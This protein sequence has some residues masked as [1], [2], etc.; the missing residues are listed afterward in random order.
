MVI[1][2]C[3][4]MKIMNVCVIIYTISYET[5]HLLRDMVKYYGI[6][7]DTMEWNILGYDGITTIRKSKNII[8]V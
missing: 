1:K 2:R 8:F 5:S 6:Q 4:M 3:V 7:W